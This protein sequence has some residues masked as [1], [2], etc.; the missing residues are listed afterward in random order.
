MILRLSADY[1]IAFTAGS[2]PRQALAFCPF[3]KAE[4]RRWNG[5]G[6]FPIPK[7]TRCS[8]FFYPRP[9]AG[10]GRSATNHVLGQRRRPHEE[11]KL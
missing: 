7:S 4:D 2:G 10:D 11:Q 3:D 6:N 9:L 8:T 5:P 1:E